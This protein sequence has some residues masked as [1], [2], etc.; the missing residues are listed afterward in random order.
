MGVGYWIRFKN[1][2]LSLCLISHRPECNISMNLRHSLRE[3][4][5]W[6]WSAG[7]L[8]VWSLLGLLKFQLSF[9]LW[10]WKMMFIDRWFTRNCEYHVL[11]TMY[12]RHLLSISMYYVQEVPIKSKEQSLDKCTV[13][14]LESI[15]LKVRDHLPLFKM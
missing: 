8:L 6:L 9:C 13:R 11:C 1:H 10:M 2:E 7:L 3:R 5:A 15:S 14:F 4:E 12:T